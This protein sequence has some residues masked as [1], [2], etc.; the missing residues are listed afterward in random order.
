MTLVV[1]FDGSELAKT[2]LVRAAQFDEILDEGI[3][4][5]SVIP[6]ENTKY[7]RARGWLGDEE[8]FDGKTIVNHLRE[9]VQEIA[10]AAEFEYTVVYR[11][12]G[13]GEIASKIRKFARQNEAS[14]VF[15]GSE[16]A[17]RILRSVSSVGGT[18]AT[19][20][21]YDTMVISH[22]VPTTIEEL[23]DAVPT[24]EVIG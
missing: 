13:A 12:A 23:E 16:N 18:V 2:A 20:R 6:T 21:A 19:D 24:D 15:I 8:P 1:P 9:Q 11:Y 3:A 10:P 14:I 7:A 4:T 17:G 22:A 5:I